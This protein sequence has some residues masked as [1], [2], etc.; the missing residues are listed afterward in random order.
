MDNELGYTKCHHCNTNFPLFFLSSRASEAH[1]VDGKNFCS[2][3][4]DEEYFQ[5]GEQLVLPTSDGW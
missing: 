5:F 2:N 4:C 3:H 1:C